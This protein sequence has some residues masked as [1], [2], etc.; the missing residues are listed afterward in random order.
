[1]RILRSQSDADEA[2][3]NNQKRSNH[4]YVRYRSA[5]WWEEKSQRG[6]VN[7]IGEKLAIFLHLSP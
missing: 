1:L 7:V 4:D 5:S 6:A 2:K 3:N